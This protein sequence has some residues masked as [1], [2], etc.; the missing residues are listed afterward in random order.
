MIERRLLWADDGQPAVCIVDV[1][2][3]LRPGEVEI[4][5][6]DTPDSVALIDL[7]FRTAD[8]KERRRG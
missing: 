8:N 2:P 1:D 6:R 7:L 3:P 4:D 5:L